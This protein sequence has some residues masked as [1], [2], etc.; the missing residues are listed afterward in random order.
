MSLRTRLLLAVLAAC[1]A[2]LTIAAVLTYTLVTS[3]QLDQVDQE[4]E[5]A[6]PPIERAAARSGHDLER[7][8][9]DAAPGFYV[10][11]RDPSGVS[12][13]VIPLQ[14]PGDDTVT[15]TTA[16][17]PEANGGGGDRDDEAV[18]ASVPSTGDHDLRVRVSRQ[19]DDSILIIGR[20]LQSIEDTRERLLVSLLAAMRRRRR[21]RRA[22]RRVAGADRSATAHRS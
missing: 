10:E 13:T 8:I 15:L 17:L 12:T 6:H 21:D 22:A 14:H 16:D 19:S 11:F 18:F 20:S 2:G 7:A 3:A 1:V 4:L 5:R 9:R